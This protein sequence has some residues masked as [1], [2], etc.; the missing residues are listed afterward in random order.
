MA[1]RQ[2]QGTG[3][4]SKAS[5]GYDVV[6]IPKEYVDTQMAIGGVQAVP[7]QKMPAGMGTV[8]RNYVP[9]GRSTIAGAGGGTSNPIPGKDFLGYRGGS[10]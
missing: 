4:W 9:Q 10:K 3:S 1:V 7:N 8:V 5:V 2:T 6:Q